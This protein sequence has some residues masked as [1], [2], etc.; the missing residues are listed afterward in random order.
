MQIKIYADVV[1][2]INLFMDFFIFWILS[3]LVKKKVPLHRIA[4]GSGLSAILYCVALFIPILHRFYNF[5]GALIILTAGILVSFR[6]KSAKELIKLL[7]FAHISA[8]AVGGAGMALFYFTNISSIV[9]NMLSF[10]IGNFSIKLLIA[11]TAS[12]YIIIKLSSGWINANIINKKS[13]CTVKIYFN[14][15]EVQATALIDTGNSL[16]EPITGAPVIVVEFNVI[17]KFIP[18]EARILFYEKDDVTIEKVTEKLEGHLLSNRLRLIPFSSLG[19]KCG[20]LIG[21]KPDKTEILFNDKDNLNLDNAIIGI[22]NNLLCKN[23]GYN[24][25]INPDAL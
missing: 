8:F 22:Y 11:S 25:L 18:P 3:R 17:S 2:F 16:T 10:S 20:M 12:I 4:L 21:F 7:F 6:P 5:F 15:Q 24:A 9:G 14:Q 13:F 19:S 1:L 23:K